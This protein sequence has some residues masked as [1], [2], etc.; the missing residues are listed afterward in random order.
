MNTSYDKENAGLCT[1]A[2][3]FELYA[4]FHHLAQELEALSIC[5]LANEYGP[6]HT[7][8]INKVIWACCSKYPAENT[9]SAQ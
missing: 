6:V 7:A 5:R 3:Y 9:F 4:D 2:M 1:C 8:S